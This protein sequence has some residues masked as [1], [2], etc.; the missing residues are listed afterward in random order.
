MSLVDSPTRDVPP[1]QKKNDLIRFFVSLALGALALWWC[2]AQVDFTEMWRAL[3]GIDHLSFLAF[4]V[5]ATALMV[6]ADSFALKRV[7]SRHVGPIDLKT[8]VV[9]RSTSHL[10]S[11]VNFH[12][13]QAWLTWLISRNR[14][15]PVWRVAGAT[16][17]GYASTFGALIVLAAGSYLM[18]P[19]AFSWL[20]PVLL[21]VALTA[22]LY[23]WVLSK[24]GAKL[25]K[26]ESLGVLVDAGFGGHVLAVVERLPHAAVLF[27]A[28]WL[29]FFFF[30]IDV[31]PADALALVPILLLVAA[32][33]ITP[34]GIGARDVVAFQLFVP[35]APGTPEEAAG[36]IA[37]YSLSWA[38]AITLGQAVV[39]IAAAPIA[40]R[41][42]ARIQGE[43]PNLEAP[44]PP[45]RA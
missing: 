17:L 31:P 6:V 8:L 42:V 27:L 36:Q 34:Q 9:L 12:L 29:P 24:F 3:S 20:G 4:M 35:Y 33:P 40:H 5:V 13:G 23:V 32:M 45:T 44:P 15:T 11:I 37:A 21:G 39:S 22:A 30:G 18:R 10:A 26:I 43:H 28:Q 7:F 38:A 41:M 19:Q 16:L 1:A 14:K 25:R 2:L